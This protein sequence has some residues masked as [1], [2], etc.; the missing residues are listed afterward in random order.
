MI[1]I[2]RLAKELQ[3]VGN[4]TIS[5]MKQYVVIVVERSAD[6]EMVCH[7]LKN[8]AAGLSRAEIERGLWNQYNRLFW[9]QQDSKALPAPK[10]TTTADRSKGK[11]RRPRKKMK[12]SRFNCGKNRH[13]AGECRCE[14]KSET[15]GNAAA[16]K[17]DKYEGKCYVRGNEEHIAHKH[18][19][20][21]KSV[22]HRT[23]KCEMRGAEEGPMLAKLNMPANSEMEPM[24]AM[25]VEARGG[26]KEEWESDSGATCHM[27]HTRAMTAYKKA[28][29]GTT[30]KVADGNILPADGFG[31]IE[32]NLYQPSNST[33]LARMGA[34]AYI[35]RLLRNLFFD[36]KPVEL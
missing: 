27:S 4:K 19:G 28:S 2:D 5:E 35:P 16:G 13:H 3:R 32:A 30:V 36:L 29:P 1:E 11:N 33:K 18:C 8:N 7:I 23:R 26:R 25:M 15:S 24:A 34:V 22:E 12:S 6:Y 17:N 20:L 31:T 21:C 9:Q 14:K 10:G